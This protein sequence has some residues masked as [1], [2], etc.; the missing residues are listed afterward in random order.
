MRLLATELGDKD[1]PG[2]NY[3]T[4]QMGN[5]ARTEKNSAGRISRDWGTIR[6]FIS[7]QFHCKV[8]GGVLSE[9]MVVVLE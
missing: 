7:V 4:L 6:D 8:G 5:L 1:K 3:H 9:Y 2:E